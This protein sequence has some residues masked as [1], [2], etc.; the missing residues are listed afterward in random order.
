M[1]PIFT[2]EV[3]Y[4][5]LDFSDD[6]AIAAGATLASAPAISILL[7]RGETAV[8]GVVLT[9]LTTP[10]RADPVIRADGK[11]IRFWALGPP[12]ERYLVRGQGLGSNNEV[13]HARDVLIVE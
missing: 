7:K 6:P 8:A 2:G 13:I 4:L 1:G 10:A 9:T 5:E 11:A 12:A 3:R